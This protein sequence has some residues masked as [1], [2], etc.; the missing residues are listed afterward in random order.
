MINKP[1]YSTFSQPA[2]L[3]TGNITQSGVNYSDKRFRSDRVYAYLDVAFYHNKIRCLADGP[4]A[5]SVATAIQI[6]KAWKAQVAEAEQR[7]NADESGE[8][9]PDPEPDAKIRLVFE[10]YV[11]ECPNT[12]S[13]FLRLC[14]DGGLCLSETGREPET[15][16]RIKT[17]SVF[18]GTYAHQLVAGKFIK[19][20]DVQSSSGLNNTK[21]ALG[22]GR[23]FRDEM[24]KIPH[25]SEGIIT[26]V[27]NGPNSVGTMFAITLDDSSRKMFDARHCAFGKAVEGFP[28]FQKELHKCLISGSAVLASCVVIE[29]CG[30]LDR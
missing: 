4:D 24:L 14:R 30:V 6:N 20:G 2:N 25:D 10:L 15:A 28:A 17:Q 27:N 5:E 18:Q 13:N 11:D 9:S 23:W 19:F 3:T 8:T 26:M 22:T 12:C 16:T 21:S 7:Y 29:D 1:L